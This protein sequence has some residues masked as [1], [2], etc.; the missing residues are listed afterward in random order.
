MRVRCIFIRRAEAI[1]QRPE[2][3]CRQ[4]VVVT[5]FFAKSS[6][7]PVNIEGN[8]LLAGAKLL[9]LNQEGNWEFKCVLSHSDPEPMQ[10]SPDFTLGI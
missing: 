10:I 1:G 6:T 7:V 2:R 9:E 3:S 5:D 8:V 4:Q